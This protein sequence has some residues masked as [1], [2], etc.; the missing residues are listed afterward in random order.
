MFQ[1]K[2]KLKKSN[3]CHKPLPEDFT[4]EIGKHFQVNNKKWEIGKKITLYTV[5]M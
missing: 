4:M 1:L 5:A 2:I 3:I